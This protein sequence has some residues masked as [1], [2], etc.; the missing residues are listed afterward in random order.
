LKCDLHIEVRFASDDLVI[1]RQP[2]ELHP[3]F[4]IHCDLLGWISKHFRF[5]CQSLAS[6]DW[7]GNLL[8]CLELDPIWIV[9]FVSVLLNCLKPPWKIIA[10]VM[11]T[12]SSTCHKLWFVCWCTIELVE[13]LVT[14]ASVLL[15]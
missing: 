10:S 15:N 6:H 13:L 14:F 9:V 2:T 11:E 1:F 3:K 8:R 4:L 12:Q 5:Y 7:I